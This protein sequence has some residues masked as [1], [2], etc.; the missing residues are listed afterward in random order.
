MGE[1]TLRLCATIARA[2]S[3]EKGFAVGVAGAAACADRLPTIATNIVK[4][5]DFKGSDFKRGDSNSR[6]FSRIGFLL[7]SR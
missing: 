7:E 2:S 3:R 5:S 4:S 6:D 1:T